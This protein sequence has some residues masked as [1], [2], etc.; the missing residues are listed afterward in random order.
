MG[1]MNAIEWDVD[2]GLKEVGIASQ[3]HHK[4]YFMILASQN[5]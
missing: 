3:E 2:E 4:A 1:W 5:I